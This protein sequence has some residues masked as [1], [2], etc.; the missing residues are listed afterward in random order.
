MSELV[1]NSQRLR[2][3]R[4]RRKMTSQS[5]A[6]A[7]GISPVTLSRLENKTNIPENETI[8]SLAKALN[9]P[10]GFFFGDDLDEV[11]KDDAKEA[12]EQIGMELVM[13]RTP[14]QYDKLIE[15]T[16]AERK[17]CLL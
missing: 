10:L 1:F 5:L 3:A 8:V 7:A 2:L 4:S 11:N 15:L 17:N 9:Y 12:C 6:K 13:P 14:E 16:V